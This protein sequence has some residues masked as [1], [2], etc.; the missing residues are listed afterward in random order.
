MEF[1]DRRNRSLL[2]QFWLTVESFKDPLESIDS[3]S[4]GDEDE[5]QPQPSTT[6]S[7]TLREDISMV[8]DLYFA[9][10]AVHPALAAISPKHVQTIR[11]FATETS[12]P[13]YVEERRVRRS[14]MLAQRQVEQDMEHDFIEFQRSELWFRV[15]G[16]LNPNERKASVPAKTTT[17]AKSP[18][19]RRPLPESLP[20]PTP[21]SS[22]A[23][24]GLLFGT[25]SPILSSTPA[26]PSASGY[27]T[28]PS[29]SKLELLMSPTSPSASDS[30][31]PLFD[32]PNDEQVLAPDEAQV[33]R[34]EAIQ[35]AL[36]DI[37]ALDKDAPEEGRVG[38]S[39]MRRESSTTDS[40][41]SPTRSPR[42]SK[43]RVLFDDEIGTDVHHPP[44]DTEE[45][46]QST[47]QLA[48][49]G[50][51]Q[52]AHEIARLTSKIESLTSQD[53]MLDTLIQ[54]AELT[55]DDRELR[56]LRQSRAAYTREL[57]ELSFQ[58]TQYEQ[59]EAA[60]RLV[61]ERTRVAIV[62][63]TTADEN[64]KSV[65]RYLVEVQQLAVDGSFASGWVVAR[66]Y[67]EFLAMHTKIRDQH[68]L[69]RNLEFP[70]K[71]LVTALSGNFV[72]TRRVALERYL[73][74]NGMPSFSIHSR[75]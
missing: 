21:S 2:V 27:F 22:S 7:Q 59:Q 11:S 64:G 40:I 28:R 66:R 62:N 5:L 31:S 4:S 71:R 6:S 69:V 75:T 42:G 46:E 18:I 39:S 65:V 33:Q 68:A 58:K 74:V 45:M 53:R 1:M 48:A 16:D 72:D 9:G 30:R 50:D 44:A 57:R 60:N 10:T 19:V 20:D 17:P 63:A 24:F 8:H 34:I 36:T 61:A 54:K 23:S 70:G 41:L 52:L 14:V 3:G 25:G 35:A 55:G 73:Q 51:L 38:A 32:D 67:N 15:I 12:P 47:F 43:R 56:L 26:S 13:T 49:P 29:H 37:M